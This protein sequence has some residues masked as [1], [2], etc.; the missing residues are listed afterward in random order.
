MLGEPGSA[1]DS[2]MT[3]CTPS[4]DV[5]WLA[6]EVSVNK[7]DPAEVARDWMAQNPKTVDGW[8]GL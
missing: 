3:R 5:S 8:L 2:V 4:D 6:Y 7:R 1:L